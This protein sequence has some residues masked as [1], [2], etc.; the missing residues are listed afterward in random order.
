MSATGIARL[1]AAAYQAGGY[2][3]VVGRGASY[4]LDAVVLIGGVVVAYVDG[5]DLSVDVR[6]E[7]TCGRLVVPGHPPLQK[8]AA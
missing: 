1:L 2:D 3:A 7:T 5:R 4:E 8:R 6:A